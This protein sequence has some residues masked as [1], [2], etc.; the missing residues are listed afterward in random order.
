MDTDLLLMI[1]VV[2]LVLAVPSLISAWA[3]SRAP[4]MGAIMVIVALGL[5][6]TAVQVKPGGYAFRDV[7][8]VMLE[9]MGRLIN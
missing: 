6:L 5:I 4:R 3:E 1:G 8:S 2:L 7:P 9:V